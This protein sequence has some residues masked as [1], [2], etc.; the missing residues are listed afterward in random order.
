MF[1]A[2]YFLPKALMV[3]L[4][5]FIFGSNF[6]LGWFIGSAFVIG[7]DS[8]RESKTDKPEVDGDK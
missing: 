8:Y 7:A 4:V 6:A 3:L 5:G 2:S 1:P